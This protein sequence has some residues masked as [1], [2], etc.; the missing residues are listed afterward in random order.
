MPSLERHVRRYI[1]CNNET[2]SIFILRN[3]AHIN[4]LEYMTHIIS[5]KID[6]IE[7]RG[8]SEDCILSIENNTNSLGWMRR[9]N[10][11]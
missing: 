1:H 10:L 7:D 4:I 2:M 9:S 3:R 11:G 8:K 5:I 6:I